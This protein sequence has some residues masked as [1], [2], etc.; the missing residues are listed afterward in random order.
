MNA[1]YFYVL[2]LKLGLIHSHLQ[3]KQQTCTVYTEVSSLNILEDISVPVLS[4][5]Q[6]SVNHN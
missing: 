3:K 6:Y 1:R 2:F 4:E 5:C